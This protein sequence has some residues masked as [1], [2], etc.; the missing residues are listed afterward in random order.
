MRHDCL[1]PAAAHLYCNPGPLGLFAYGMTACSLM[2]VNMSWAGAKFTSAVIGFGFAYAGLTQ[3]VAGVMEAIR[4][5]TFG[6]TGER[7]S[8]HMRNRL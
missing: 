7:P 4:G 2:F 3:W 5:N 1:P 8:Q 6:A